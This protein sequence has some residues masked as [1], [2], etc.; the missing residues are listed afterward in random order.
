MIFQEDPAAGTWTFG[1][2]GSSGSASGTI[3]SWVLSFY[4]RFLSAFFP[5][6]FLLTTNIQN[7][8][9]GC[10]G[11]PCVNG[12]CTAT[13]WDQGQYTCT[14][15]AGW[16]GSTC[17]TDINECAQGT[18]NCAATATCTNT[19]GSFTCKCNTG[20]TGSGVT[21]TGKTKFHEKCDEQ[22]SLKYEMKT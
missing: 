5:L 17:A 19:P 15:N 22:R 6:F 16:T 2:Y 14:C 13:G 11:G 20:Y 18:D 12:A 9:D 10:I 8:S 7:L 4:S 21:C 1:V 3:S